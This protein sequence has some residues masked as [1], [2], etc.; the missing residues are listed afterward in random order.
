MAYVDHNM[1]T[2]VKDCWIADVPIREALGRVDALGGD[3]TELREILLEDAAAKLRGAI[4]TGDRFI[5]PVTTDTWP[6]VKP[7]VE[8]LLRGLRATARIRAHR[9]Q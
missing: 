5:D 6:Q 1:G 4:A 2:I 7:L 3:D 8:W 9:A